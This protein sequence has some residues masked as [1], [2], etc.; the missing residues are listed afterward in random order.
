MS[1]T[2]DTKEELE[3][4][5]TSSWNKINQFIDDKMNALPTPIYSSVDIRESKTKFAPVDMNMY[6]AGFNNLCQL[7]LDAASR[8]FKRAIKQVKKE[9]QTVAIIPE[10]HTKNLFYLDH[11]GYLKKSIEDAGFEIVFVSLDNALFPSEERELNLISHSQFDIVFHKGAITNGELTANDQVIDLA[12][13]NHDQSNPLEVPWSDIKTPVL[14]TPF[15]GWYRRQKSEHFK[16]YETVINEFS[17][18]FNI[19]P[20][21]LMARYSAIENVDF[22]SKDGLENVA[23]AVDELKELI[24][25]EAKI[26][27]K[28]SQGTYGMGISVVSSGSEISD[29]NRKNRDKMNIGKNKIKFTSVV[30][31]EGVE[32]ILRYDD[33]AAEVTIYL[34]SG[35]PT[36]G[37]VRANSQRD[38]K[39]NLNSR[40]MVFKKY[41][42]SEIRENNDS[43]S[44]EAVYSV[45]ARL[46]TMAGALEIKDVF[47]EK[48]L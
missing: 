30:V 43:Q 45:I 20:N 38:S 12:I 26:F 41:C 15:I 9:A 44:K 24:D 3:T 13:L 48:G 19:D 27:V 40:G 37:F 18:E 17:Q 35:K 2:I 25:S 32:S 46:A 7:D 33:M 23:N 31:Q 28:A 14:P 21:L 6:P 39:E 4:F 8:L 36:G 47:K 34:V 5:V 16:N 42:I 22:S 29:M 10:S 1:Y 11:L